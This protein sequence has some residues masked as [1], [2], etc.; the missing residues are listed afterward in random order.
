MTDT[1]KV[2]MEEAET[3]TGLAFLGILSM[4][5]EENGIKKSAIELDAEF[6]DLVQGAT[7]MTYPEA[8][9]AQPRRV[10]EIAL[11]RALRIISPETNEPE[12]TMEQAV[13]TLFDVRQAISIS[14]ESDRN[15]ISTGNVALIRDV[16]NQ[17]VEKATEIKLAKMSY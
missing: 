7:R 17:L 16:E 12:A 13:R 10:L 8:M 11:R 5:Y 2:Q 1:E 3:V 15:L 6:V 4:A 9:K 14:S